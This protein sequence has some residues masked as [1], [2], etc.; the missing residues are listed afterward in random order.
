LFPHL[1]N[2]F[3]FGDMLLQLLAL[4]IIVVTVYHISLLLY[5]RYKNY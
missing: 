4:E 3:N 2:V 1:F 5:F